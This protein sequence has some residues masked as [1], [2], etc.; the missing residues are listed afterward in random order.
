MPWKNLASGTLQGLSDATLGATLTPM[1]RFFLTGDG[2]RHPPFGWTSACKGL[3]AH[4]E[5]LMAS[6]M[7]CA[8]VEEHQEE[9]KDTSVPTW[10]PCCMIKDASLGGNSQFTETCVR[11][12]KNART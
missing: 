12:W 2:H 5:R 3:R 6:Q 11:S 8:H 10:F 1:P 4:F 9:V 7:L